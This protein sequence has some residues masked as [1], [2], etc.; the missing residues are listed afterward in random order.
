MSREYDS[1]ITDHLLQ[2]GLVDEVDA[3][4]LNELIRDARQKTTDLAQKVHVSRPTVYERIQ[5]L[6]QE[7]RII[8]RYTTELDFQSCNL[9]LT[10]FILVGMDPTRAP[11]VDQREIGKQISK[12]RYVRQVNLITGN[13][14]FIV[15][16][17]IDKMSTLAE[18]I[19]DQLR[20]IPG[21]GSTQTMTSFAEFINGRWIEEERSKS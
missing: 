9:T 13:Y 16:V 5:K 10:A 8:N 18:V 21:V 17:V 19:I 7:K 12:L 20:K 14:D 4:L 2:E 11:D 1:W 3:I 15:S 6:E